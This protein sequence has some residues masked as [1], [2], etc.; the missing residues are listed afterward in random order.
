[1]S[2]E[3]KLMVGDWVDY[4]DASLIAHRVKV[5]VSDLVLIDYAIK[6]NDTTVV[7]KPIPLK[8]DVLERIGFNYDHV[9]YYLGDIMLSECGNGFTCW[10]KHFG[11]SN[12]LPM[13]ITDLH[14]LQQLIRLF[15]NKEIEIKW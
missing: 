7:Y 13:V 10:Y 11:E 4:T 15:C 5:E 12:R 2:K 14:T 9:T 1:M 6:N 3:L 8:P